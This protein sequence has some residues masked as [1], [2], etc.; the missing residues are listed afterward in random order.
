MVS[1]KNKKNGL[2]WYVYDFSNN[3][4]AI[5]VDNLLDIHSYLMKNNDIVY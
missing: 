3:Y 5:A 2:T 4:N 1:R